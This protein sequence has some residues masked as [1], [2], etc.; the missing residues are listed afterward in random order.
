MV[1]SQPDNFEPQSLILLIPIG[2]II[3]TAIV[4]ILFAATTL[5]TDSTGAGVIV[6]I[7]FCAVLP[8]L[9][10]LHEIVG[11]WSGMQ[12][13]FMAMVIVPPIVL[14]TAWPA[15]VLIRAWRRRR[16][17]GDSDPAEVIAADQHDQAY[18]RSNEPETDHLVK[19]IAKGRGKDR[20]VQGDCQEC[21]WSTQR[22]G[23]GH[24]PDRQ[25]RELAAKH[26]SR[27]VGGRR[28]MARTGSSHD[29][30]EP[31]PDRRRHRGHRVR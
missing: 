2:L 12:D 21:D 18:D 28:A 20:R 25:V 14:V 8:V 26:F 11:D 13:V 29:P 5:G 4:F 10:F 24:W 6:L 7:S 3:F 23:L 22:T 30:A 9:G 15:A 19:I 27:V 31:C 17:S 1:I 16:R